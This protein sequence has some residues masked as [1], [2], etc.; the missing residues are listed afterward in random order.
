MADQFKYSETFGSLSFCAC[1]DC[2]SIYSPAAYLADILFFLPKDPRDALLSAARRPDLGE[3]ELSCANTTTPLPYIDLVNEV[4]EYAVA[5]RPATPPT[6]PPAEPA[7][8]WPQTNGE[9]SDVASSPEH[10]INDAYTILG[11]AIYSWDLPFDLWAAQARVYLEKLGVRRADLMETFQDQRGV[12]FASRQSDSWAA[13]NEVEIGAEYLGITPAERR[14]ITARLS[15]KPVLIALTAMPQLS[16]VQ[17]LDG[18]Q[19]ADGDRVLVAAGSD[20]KNGIYV[21]HA[22][23]WQRPPDADG[24]T[25]H[26]GVMAVVNKGAQAG[27]SWVLTTKEPFKVDAD[28][29]TFAPFVQAGEP[30]TM[31]MP[32]WQA[33]YA[34]TDAAK[35]A[36]DRITLTTHVRYLLDRSGLEFQELDDLL[37]TRYINSAVKAAD[38]F[39]IAFDP[40]APCDVDSATFPNPLTDPA[41]SRIHRFVRLR[42]KLGWTSRELDQAIAALKAPDLTDRFLVQLSHIQRIHN[43]L[44]VPL[45]ELFS[46]WSTLDTTRDVQLAPSF[47]EQTFQN[48]AVLT[49]EG[50]VA[51]ALDPGR[52][53]LAAT[54]VIAPAHQAG[55]I[56]ALGISADDLALLLDRLAATSPNPSLNIANLSWLYRHASLARALQRPI[57]ELLSLLDLSGIE[58]FDPARSASIQRLMLISRQVTNSE[59]SIAELDYLLRDRVEASDGIAPTDEAVDVALRDLQTGLRKITADT[60]PDQDPNGDQLRGKLA[61]L[62][63]PADVDEAMKVAKGTSA[64]PAKFIADH[65]GA[66]CDPDDALD[67]LV[68]HPL[69]SEGERFA[70]LTR[71]LLGA[72]LVAQKLAAAFRLDTA[73]VSPLVLKGLRSPSGGRSALAELLDSVF[74]AAT[75]SLPDV[76]QRTWLKIA[77]A[78]LVLQRFRVTTD[79]FGT[80][81]DVAWLTNHATSLGW[82]D[83]DALPLNGGVAVPHP[84]PALFNG[85][86]RLADLYAVWDAQPRGVPSLF[87]IIDLA[88]NPKVDDYLAAL[89]GRT[90]WKPDDLQ[91]LANNLGL[92][93]PDDYRDERAL[94]RYAAC[95]RLLKKLRVSAAQV[96]PWR[97]AAT[98]GGSPAAAAREIL[99]AT[100]ARFDSASWSQAAGPLQDLIR[101]RRRDALVAYL[102]SQGSAAGHLFADTDALFEWYLLDVE[103]TPVVRTSRIKQAIG[104][105]QLF[106]QRAIMNLEDGVTIGADNASH[107]LT[108]MQSEQLWEANRKVFLYPEN[109]IEEDLLLNATPFFEDLKTDLLQREVTLD[110]AEEAYRKYLDQLERV[111]RLEVMGMYH[112][113]PD[114][115]YDGPEVLHVFGRTANDP[116]LYFYRT[117][118]YDTVDAGVWSPWERVD[119]DIQ[120]D[121]LIPVVFNRRLH[122]FWPLF[123]EVVDQPKVKDQNTTHIEVQLAW[124]EYRNG[125][126]L[127]KKLGAAKAGAAGARIL[128]HDPGLQAFSFQAF[129]ADTLRVRIRWLE[130]RNSEMDDTVADI[131]WEFTGCS[132][133]PTVASVDAQDLANFA[134]PPDMS[135]NGM[136]FHGESDVQPFSLPISGPGTCDVTYYR[137]SLFDVLYP[138]QYEN[139]LGNDSF[140]YQD[141][142]RTFFA[143]YLG[144]TTRRPGWLSTP[145]LDAGVIAAWIPYTGAERQALVNPPRDEAISLIDAESIASVEVSAAFGVG[146]P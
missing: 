84:D 18:V 39:T 128:P 127:R 121:Q 43:E 143:Q 118:T 26:D 90:G 93:Y 65:F 119:L 86:R 89:A 27:T 54:P 31:A 104:S 105:V 12:T 92:V 107:W 22:G 53:E 19:L 131:T 1:T 125:K 24:T 122:L 101:Q 78:A 120:S 59:F 63:A 34:V 113:R 58:P 80:P 112:Q 41:L 32:P 40:A 55:I 11:D 140:F 70:Y 114:V 37:Q 130:A 136:Q 60:P 45:L 9:E 83:L 17:S 21:V 56:A 30:D 129:S 33:W 71:W 102:T 73:V 72:G 69:P 2:R 49:A 20:T 138:H 57:T 76:T 146:S 77:K 10:I 5:V 35:A 68:T 124:S 4:L 7:P 15:V 96:L 95:A 134:I 14:I 109:W 144:N 81:A 106:I 116:H 13:P 79:R 8:V 141:L 117:L 91:A 16:G 47:Y 88:A 38:L 82:L 132:A 48:P 23:P 126:W 100:K 87:A 62:L 52:K 97:D 66:F 123:T 133:S 74:I 50:S 75:D 28:P 6:P 111:G 137:L 98:G 51:F 46:W 64:N 135:V 67:K 108:W 42:R 94:V 142:Q 85:W 61:T 36:T 29:L 3:I 99:Q 145:F 139:Y 110:S 44:G 103:V 115:G 25:V